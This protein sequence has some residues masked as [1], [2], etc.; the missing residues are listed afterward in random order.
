MEKRIGNLGR[1]LLVALLVLTG[2]A[3]HAQD[4]T[5]TA[6]A[7]GTDV[8]L[9]ESFR[10]VFTANTTKGQIEVPDFSD[11]HV[12]GGPASQV[13][14]SWIY[15]RSRQQKSITYELMPKKAGHFELGPAIL[16]VKGKQIKSN[17]LTFSVSKG[18][19]RNDPSSQL[20]EKAVGMTIVPNKRKVYVGEAIAL[21]YKFQHSLQVNQFTPLQVPSLSTYCS[22]S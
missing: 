22:K 11:F 14:S 1:S 2:T 7:S 9:Q 12:L 15:G 13:Q 4:W 20:L 21:T 18:V 5:I 17:I 3:L 16:K 19:K 8:G 6:S 10:V